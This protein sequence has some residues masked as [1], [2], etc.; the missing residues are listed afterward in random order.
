M[1]LRA[2][3]QRPG[4]LEA[5]PNGKEREQAGEREGREGLLLQLPRRQRA[6]HGIEDAL[7]DINAIGLRSRAAPAQRPKDQGH[8]AAAQNP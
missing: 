2:D 8:D 7:L 5:S 4:Q 1:T 3:G 6:K